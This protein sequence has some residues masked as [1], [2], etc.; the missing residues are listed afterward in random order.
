MYKYASAVSSGLPSLLTKVFWV[1]AFSTCGEMARLKSSVLIAPGD[2]KLTRIGA[3]STASPRA[4]PSALEPLEAG[5]DHPGRGFHEFTPPVM[6]KLLSG[7]FSLYS[8]RCLAF[9]QAVNQQR[10]DPKKEIEETILAYFV[11]RIL[12]CRNI[13]ISYES[14]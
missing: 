4:N 11:Y 14:P 3:K 1:N 12:F 9:T 10:S 5:S 6:V 7:D 13:S 8:S 2:T